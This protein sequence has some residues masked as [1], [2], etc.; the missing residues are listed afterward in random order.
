MGEHRKKCL[1]EFVCKPQRMLGIG[2]QKKQTPK[3]KLERSHRLFNEAD[4]KLLRRVP[5]LRLGGFKKNGPSRSVTY[6]SKWRQCALLWV[7]MAHLGCAV[8]VV[9]WSGRLKR[10]L[11]FQFFW[12][13]MCRKR[14]QGP[15]VKSS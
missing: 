4:S 11:I 1:C 9:C 15:K 13:A 14:A 6:P 3:E 10:Y 2:N 5:T 8:V 12:P 7:P